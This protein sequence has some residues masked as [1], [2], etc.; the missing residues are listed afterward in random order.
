MCLF[1]GAVCTALGVGD[2]CT[3]LGEGGAGGNVGAYMC[4]DGLPIP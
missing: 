4:V 1:E 3:A 2:V